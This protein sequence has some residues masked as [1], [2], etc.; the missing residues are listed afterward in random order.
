M[1]NLRNSCGGTGCEIQEHEKRLGHDQYIIDR[2]TRTIFSNKLMNA[3]QL[4]RQL[5][6]TFGSNWR[7]ANVGSFILLP[8]PKLN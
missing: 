1:V 7:E 3:G 8:T 2:K 5:K 6:R 4:H